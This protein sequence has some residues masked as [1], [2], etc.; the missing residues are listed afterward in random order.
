MH[1]PVFSVENSFQ[2]LAEVPVLSEGH[3]GRLV[4]YEQIPEK[5]CGVTGFA[6]HIMGIHESQGLA[7]AVGSGRM[8]FGTQP[9]APMGNVIASRLVSR[10]VVRSGSVDEMVPRR[11]GAVVCGF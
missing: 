6:V 4:D 2:A 8:G 9:L 11:R 1:V 10:Y 5:S 3:N 7:L